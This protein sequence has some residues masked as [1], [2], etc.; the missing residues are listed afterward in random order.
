M[1]PAPVIDWLQ[2]AALIYA[3]PMLNRVST[4]DHMDFVTESVQELLNNRCMRKVV[5]KPAICSPLSVVA[6]HS[7]KYRLVL[8]LRHLNQ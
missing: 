5:A 6:N 7:G 3:Y 2:V 8:N 1:A 4:L